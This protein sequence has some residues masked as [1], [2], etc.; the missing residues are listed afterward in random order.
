MSPESLSLPLSLSFL[1]SPFSL[2][3]SSHSFPSLHMSIYLL[4]RYFPH[5]HPRMC[6]S[7][8]AVIHARTLSLPSPSPQTPLSFPLLILKVCQCSKKVVGPYL[9]ACNDF[10]PQFPSSF[11]GT[12]S[13]I[14]Y[15]SHPN[16]HTFPSP[17]KRKN[18]K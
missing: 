12:Y 6:M 17:P 2:S 16:T 3:L 14:T 10:L 5:T 8:C 1:L 13:W 11:C 15:W 4:F 9:F 7:L 18:P